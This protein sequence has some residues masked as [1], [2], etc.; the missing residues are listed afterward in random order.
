[1]F[2]G[3]DSHKKTLAA[4]V[5][6]ELGRQQHSKTFDNDRQG[7]QR[8]LRWLTGAGVTVVGVEGAGHLGRVASATMLAAGLDVREVP[9]KLTATERKRRRGGGKNDPID[10]LAIAR[11]TARDV[12]TLQPARCT[13]DSAEE[14]RLLS[15][16]RQQLLAERTRLVNRV[17]ADLV[18]LAPGYTNKIPALTRPQHLTTARRLLHGHTGVRVEITRRRLSRIR[19]IDD[20]AKGLLERLADG[21]EDTGSTLTQLP[22]LGVVSAARILGETGD[23]RRFRDHNAY[24]SANGTA[25]VDD[26]SGNR[27][28][29]RL[30][31]GGNRMLNQAIHTVALAQQRLDGP[32]KAYVDRHRA[33]GRT[34][35]EA[36]RALKRR[37]SDVIYRTMLRDLEPKA[38]TSESVPANVPTDARAA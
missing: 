22:G 6:D 3:I 12:E 27:N 5:V 21:V 19:A 11:I 16:Y 15:D 7:H 34:Q 10:A 26:K 35:R 28:V 8:L 20:E 4:A 38:G 9:C 32:G 14:L 2:A 30:N 29:I 36:M 33:N 37:L 24:A 23:V 13:D 1:V 18:V 25:P 31:T 17:H